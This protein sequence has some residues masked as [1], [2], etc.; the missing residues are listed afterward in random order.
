MKKW[1]AAVMLSSFAVFAHAATE[2]VTNG[3]FETGTFA[4]WTKSGNTSLSDV[5][6]NTTTS[7]HS[8]LWRSGATG[9]PASISQLLTTV[10][11]GTYDLSFDIYSSGVSASNPASVSFSVLFNGVNIYSFQNTTTPWTHL[12]FSNLVATGAQTEL[13][14]SSRNDPS[15][16]RL[17]N[18]SVMA[19]VPEPETYAMLLA[20]MGVMAAVARRRKAVTPGL[21]G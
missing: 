21:Q 17:D 1:L 11:G 8:F 19:A 13:K 5:I 14:F 15:F 16:T 3:N 10:A 4:G 6:A 12:T 2:L 7:N 20:G 18:V 9:S